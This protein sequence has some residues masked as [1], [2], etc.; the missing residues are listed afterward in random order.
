M[1]LDGIRMP[2]GCY[3]DGTWELSVHVTDLG[4]D[5]TLRVT[6]EI[7][8]GGVML[9]LVEKLGECRRPSCPSIPPRG[10]APMLCFSCGDCLQPAPGH[11][12]T[13]SAM[14]QQPA[15]RPSTVPRCFAPPP[16]ARGLP[17]HPALELCPRAVCLN[18][19]NPAA[20]LGCSTQ[21][22]AAV[23]CF[24]IQPAAC[25]QGT[26]P[27]S[28]PS[29]V[30]NHPAPSACLHPAPRALPQYCASAPDTKPPGA[31]LW[32][33]AP[34]LYAT[35]STLLTSGVRSWT[36]SSLWVPSSLG[37]NVIHLDQHPA[38]IQH[39]PLAR[40]PA[41]CPSALFQSSA[42][43]R[44]PLHPSELHPDPQ[45]HPPCTHSHHPRVLLAAV[46]TELSNII[47]SG[48]LVQVL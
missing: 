10:S 28:H 32:H 24:S 14:P 26:A 2:D 4:R 33:P 40:P 42:C 29:S 20:I 15:L 30:L 18:T 12:P 31:V 1:A 23:F 11:C 27:A 43:P 35:P 25:T 36:P 8:I 41:S 19:Q 7:H 5:V 46:C 21:R 9:R 44:L 22:P 6:G 48:C 37:Y 3:A 17:Q 45:Q 34:C 13:S 39:L 16:G 47:A 38:Y